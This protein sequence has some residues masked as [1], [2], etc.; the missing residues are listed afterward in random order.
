MP[1]T[2]ILIQIDD[3]P[4]SRLNLVIS[5]QLTSSKPH[6]VDYDLTRDFGEIAD[7]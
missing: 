6:A 4:S 1:D 5:A 3:L 7:E 2:R